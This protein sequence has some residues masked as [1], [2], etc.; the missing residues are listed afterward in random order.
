MDPFLPGP[1]NRKQELEFLEAKWREP[2]AQFIVL[3]GKRRVG[4]TELVKQ[5]ISDKPNAYFLAESTS[6]REQLHRFSQ[7][8]GRYFKEP[9]LETRGFAGWEEGFDYVRRKNERFVLAID[10]FPYLIWSNPAIAGLFQKA[11]DEYWS[12]S[13]IYLILLGSSMAM[14]ENE[15]MGYRSPLYGR[16]TGQLRI[17]P[18]DIAAAGRFHPGSSFADILQHY[19][20]AGGIPAYWLQ[21][22]ADKDFFQNLADQVLRK[23]AMLYDEVEFILREALREPRY[24]FALLQAIAQGKRKLAEI[25][26]ATGIS[27]PV[28]NK[29]LGVLADL[30]I[31]ERELP[32]TEEKPLKSKKGLYRITDNFFRF[33]FRFVF[34]RRGELEMGRIEAVLAAIRQGLS[35]YLGEIY[36]QAAAE[37]LKNHM[38]RFFPFSAVGRWWDRSEE[39]DLVA[40]NSE[41][42][43]ILFAEVKWTEKPVGIDIYESLR[44]KSGQVVWGTEHRREF[45][46]LFSKSGFTK[47]MMNCAGEDG[48]VLFKEDIVLDTGS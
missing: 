26:N 5:F 21:L 9:L 1:N 32:V 24:Y 42:D 37:T 10:E 20:V 16:R 15:V 39:I 2:G 4:K 25:V 3:W 36:E 22:S 27:Q 12:G 44:R 18:L 33:W 34:P 6:D 41:L 8:L 13:G 23:G 17:D 38:D 11:W 48:V 47:A 40:V 14:M 29:Y 30:R 7:V 19:S 46:C 43:S 31:V 28:A 35:P 45:F